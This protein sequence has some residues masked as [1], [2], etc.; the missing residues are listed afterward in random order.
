MAASSPSVSFSKGACGIYWQS[1]VAIC[2]G[3]PSR[4]ISSHIC[5]TQPTLA[6]AGSQPSSGAPEAPAPGSGT[7]PS[8]TSSSP[9]RGNQLGPAHL[10]AAHRLTHRRAHAPTPCPPHRIVSDSWHNIDES[11]GAEVVAARS[12]ELR[13][14]GVEVDHFPTTR[15]PKVLT[16][17]PLSTQCPPARRREAQGSPSSATGEVFAGAR[18]PRP[19]RS[20]SARATGSEGRRQPARA[21]LGASGRLPPSQWSVH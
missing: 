15:L 3:N 6:A 16:F 2:T 9:G 12:R 13:L 11:A 10:A 4:T 21:Q 1:R 20:P 19:Q 18:A 8:S 14:P 7:Y 5:F 17:F